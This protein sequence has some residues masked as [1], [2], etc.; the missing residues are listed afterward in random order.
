MGGKRRVFGPDVI[1]SQLG[2]TV[3]GQAVDVG[4]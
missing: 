1:L 4:G 2:V 3:G